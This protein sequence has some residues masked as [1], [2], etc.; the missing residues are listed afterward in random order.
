MNFQELYNLPEKCIYAFL[1]QKDKKIYIGFTKNLLQAL[2]RNLYYMKYS[3]HP[4]KNDIANLELI[5]LENIVTDLDLR[6]RYEYYSNKYSNEGWRLYRNYKAID[7]KVSI[8]VINIAISNG[9]PSIKC[10]VK[11]RRRGSN[12][13]IVGIFNSVSEAELFVS[14]KYS[15]GVSNIIYADN[16]LTLDF[17]G[18]VSE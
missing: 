2:E 15:N 9:M 18:K 13:L 1:N 14:D 3:N 11:L 6:L 7:Y 5:V 10:C 8:D 4:C 12:E 17:L 16:K